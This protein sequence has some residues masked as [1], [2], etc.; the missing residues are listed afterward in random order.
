MT[1]YLRAWF[2]VD[3]LAAIPFELVPFVAGAPLITWVSLFR[4]NRLLRIIRGAE[5]VGTS[6]AAVERAFAKVKVDVHEAMQMLLIFLVII[7]VSHV[8]GCFWHIL[9]L[10]QSLVRPHDALS[11]WATADGTTTRCVGMGTG[12]GVLLRRHH[13]IPPPPPCNHTPPTPPSQARCTP[14]RPFPTPAP[15][16]GPSQ[17][18]PRRATATSCPSPRWST[19]SRASTFSSAP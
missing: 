15:S 5:Y 10:A 4:L 13:T 3:V 14:S 19:S 2:A 12:G 1:R 7:L 8:A 6:R 11:D 9:A 18:S 17:Q 16:T